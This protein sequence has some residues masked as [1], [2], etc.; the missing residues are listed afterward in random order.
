VQRSR[1]DT[2]GFPHRAHSAESRGLSF[3]SPLELAR[4]K[5]VLSPPANPAH[6]RST[7]TSVDSGSYARKKFRQRS[8]NT[9]S[10][11]VEHSVDHEAR[12]EKEDRKSPYSGPAPPVPSQ[13][14][15]IAKKK[16]AMFQARKGGSSSGSKSSE[17]QNSRYL[18]CVWLQYYS[19]RNHRY[20][21]KA[22]VGEQSDNNLL[23][24]SR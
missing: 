2:G 11:S 14:E 6:V 13:E 3:D 15:H 22:R 20:Y 17:M 9:M 23:G 19:A 21:H 16:R 18:C 5:R 8:E 12:E 7:T 10:L 4:P 24:T 1:S